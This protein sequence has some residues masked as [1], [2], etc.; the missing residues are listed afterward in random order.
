[1]KM[2]ISPS[3]LD[4]AIPSTPSRWH[5]QFSLALASLAFGQS[6][7]E[8]CAIDDV[9]ISLMTGLE[10]MGAKVEVSGDTCIVDGGLFHPRGEIDAE[11]HEDNLAV[12]AG[13]ASNLPRNSRIQ[14][15]SRRGDAYPYLNALMALGV[16][17]SSQAKGRESPWLLRGPSRNSTTHVTGDIPPAFICSLVLA[18][19]LRMRDYEITIIP[20]DRSISMMEL[21]VDSMSSFG[22]GMAAG[23]GRVRVSGLE[24]LRPTKVRIR[25]DSEL[26]AYPLV[27]GALC[28]RVT[29]GGDMTGD[30]SLAAIMAFD[31]DIAAS[32]SQVTVRAGDLNGANV[33]LSR[34]PRAFP[35]LAVLATRARGGT[36]LHSAN[37]PGR[38]TIT[39]TIKLLRRMGCLAKATEDGAVIPYAH[40]QGCEL[41]ELEDPLVAMAAMVAGCS[42]EGETVISNP[43]IAEEECPGFIRHMMSLGALFYE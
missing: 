34:C 11:A 42:A 20:P 7:L 43:Q 21:V 15:Q 8:R 13:V 17:V 38:D 6:R 12:L 9:T 35:A 2:I 25:D 37:I 33:D 24:P 19:V 32:R 26:A 31:A 5:T 4:G 10:A 22:M 14:F 16:S 29:V 1:M 18:G 23:M 41:G 28:G 39:P 27:A 3:V 40:L 30:P 36:V